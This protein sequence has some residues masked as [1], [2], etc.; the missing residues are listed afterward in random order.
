M[1]EGFLYLPSIA[2]TDVAENGTPRS[3]MMPRCAYLAVAN[4]DVLEHTSN[5]ELLGC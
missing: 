4:S 1:R 3:F 2:L 5:K